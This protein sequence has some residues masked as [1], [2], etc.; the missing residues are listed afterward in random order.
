MRNSKSQNG[1]NLV[2]LMIVIAIVGIIASVA[3]PSYLNQVRS[4][5]RADCAGALTSLA[6]AMERHYSINGSYLAA[7]TGGANTGVPAVFTGNCPVDGGT[8]NYTLTI[9]A[10][11]TST[12]SLN[13]APAGAQTSDKCGTLS[14]SNTGVKGVLSA[15]AGVTWQECW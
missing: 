14:L 6:N 10:A 13:A 12:Y 15:H 5:K 3:Y 1:F 9:Q 11:T 4:T 8:A 2:E 7:A